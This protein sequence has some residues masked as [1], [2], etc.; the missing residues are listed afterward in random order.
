M[1]SWEH[2]FSQY[3]YDSAYCIVLSELLCASDKNK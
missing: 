3:V 1:Y 2:F